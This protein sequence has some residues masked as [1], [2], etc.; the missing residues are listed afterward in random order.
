[1]L[2]YYGQPV[3][4]V[5]VIILDKPSNEQRNA[6]HAVIAT[7][8]D[9]WWHY[10]NNV[11]LVTDFTA[12]EWRSALDHV[13]DMKPSSSCLVLTLPQNKSERW[14]AMRSQSAEKKAEWLQQML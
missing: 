7:K 9:T 8:C 3:P 13:V 14:W 6:A 11:W 2:P 1:M 5:H 10:F 4:A 12:V